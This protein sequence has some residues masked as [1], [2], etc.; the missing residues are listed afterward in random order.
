MQQFA[1]GALPVSIAHWLTN[2]VATYGSWTD[3]GAALA[4]ATS[5]TAQKNAAGVPGRVVALAP[6]ASGGIVLQSPTA[7]AWRNVAVHAEG[8]TPLTVRDAVQVDLLGGA[9]AD[10]LTIEG[11]KRGTVRSGAGNDAITIRA[12]SNDDGAINVF[13]VD[14]GTGDDTVAFT[15]H[16]G[17]TRAQIDLGEGNDRLTIAKVRYAVIQAGAGDDTLAVAMDGLYRIDGGAG[18]DVVQLGAKLSELALAMAADGTVTAEIAGRRDVGIAMTGVEWLRFS[19]GTLRSVAELFAAPPAPA[20]A[21]PAAVATATLPGVIRATPLAKPWSEATADPVWSGKVAKWIN[22]TLAGANLVTGTDGNDSLVPKDSTDTM[23]G[24]LGDDRYVAGDGP[25]VIEKPGEG[26][27]LVQYYGNGTIVAPDNVEN[28]QLNLGNRATYGKHLE[29]IGGIGGTSAI[30]N[31][32][33]NTLLGS[34]GD[35]TLDGMGNNDL[36]TGGGGRDTFVFGTGYGQDRIADFTPGQDRIRLLD[37]VPGWEALKP[38]LRDTAAGAQLVLGGDTLTLTGRKVAELSARDFEFTLDASR[39]KLVFDDEFDGFSRFDGKHGDGGTWRT[40]INHTDGYWNVPED[41]Q[42]YLDPGT[43]GVQPI[44]VKDGVA[45]IRAEYHPE[46]AAQM[47]GREYTSAAITTAGS[48]SQQ[49]GYFEARLKLSEGQ[50]LWPAFW[51]LPTDNTW[52]PEIDIVE[53]LGRQPDVAHQMG[54]WAPVDTTEWHTYGLEW[55]AD[56]LAWFIDGKMTH[57]VYNHN[58]HTPMYIILNLAVGGAWPGN[59]VAPGASGALLGDMQI[60]YVRAY[61]DVGQGVAA[62]GTAAALAASAGRA[63]PDVTFSVGKLP[64]DGGAPADTFHYVADTHGTMY[65]KASDF[66]IAALT[67]AVKVQV[68]SNRA[69][70]AYYVDPD[71]GAIGLNVRIADADGGR[72]TLNDLALVDLRLGGSGA[73]KV[74]LTRVQGGLVETGAGDDAIAIASPQ[75][76]RGGDSLTF[77]VRSGAGNDSIAGPASGKQVLLVEAGAGADTVVGGLN[78]DTL[79]G[80][81]GDDVLT[82][83]KGADVFLFRATDPGKDHVTDFVAGTDRLRFEGIAKADLRVADTAEGAMISWNGGSAILDGIKAATAGKWMLDFA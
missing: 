10:T 77:T 66:G 1:I 7:W 20:P 67:Q 55:T 63:A 19:D 50:G 3:P 16:A 11:A 76:W 21:P 75:V 25:T 78:A 83:G 61:Q 12:R 30:G 53:Q 13:V 40:R 64:A 23:A 17:L 36:L 4:L 18:N 57:V 24:G 26:I 69:D 54:N 8:G 74:T 79:A 71:N 51:M 65:F 28:I 70:D 6:G 72:Y 9:L 52:P 31:A 35:N 47:G 58:Q 56:R 14:A 81:A 5:A 59:P 48:F 62:G 39:Y 82:G 44:V 49:Y 43:F 68:S 73:S 80:G 27:D 46:L 15:G 45:T 22:D 38:L 2:G 34:E 42:Y 41:K 29:R 32:L 37:G 33:A 60:D